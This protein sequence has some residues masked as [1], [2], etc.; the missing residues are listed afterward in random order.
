MRSAE[1]DDNF[2][3]GIEGYPTIEELNNGHAS[4]NRFTMTKK[5]TESSKKRHYSQPGLSHKSRGPASTRPVRSMASMD[6]IV[7]D[8]IQRKFIP[9]KTITDTNEP[10]YETTGPQ[11]MAI[12]AD[13]L[14]SYN[15]NNER[16]YRRKSAEGLNRSNFSNQDVGFPNPTSIHEYKNNA[17]STSSNDLR[18]ANSRQHKISS[19][20]SLASV[21]MLDLHSTSSEE[22][23]RTFKSTL[24]TILSCMYALFLLTLGLILFI[25]DIFIETRLSENYCL[26]LVI[27][28]LIYL[29]YLYIDIRIYTNKAHKYHEEKKQYELSEELQRAGLDQSTVIPD[30]VKQNVNLSKPATPPKPLD[31][32]Y[33]FTQGRHAGSFYLKMGAAAFFL[34]HLVH[35]I[36]F[37]SLQVIYLI[38]DLDDDC[39]SIN[40]LIL[41]I[42]YPLYSCIQLFFIFKYSNVIIIKCKELGR[43]ALMHCIASSLCF[44]VW[45]I[46]R[47]I[48][49]SLTVYAKKKAQKGDYG[50]SSEEVKMLKSAQPWDPKF[51]FNIS[52]LADDV[53][54]SVH[55]F[56][57]IIE[58][59]FPY[60]YPF[61]IEFSILIAGVFFILW[62]NIDS[63]SKEDDVHAQNDL[64][65]KTDWDSYNTSPSHETDQCKIPTPIDGNQA[66]SNLTLS[67]DCHSSN[68][69]W[70]GGLMVLVASI[71]SIIVCFIAISNKNTAP[72]GS[73]LK[74]VSELCLHLIMLVAA[75][76]AYY[77]IRR[78][79]VNPHP[80]S[81]LDDLLLF[82]CIPAFYMEAC[83]TL[84]PTAIHL[85]FVKFFN[86]LLMVLQVTVQTP[87]IIDALRRCSNSRKLRKIKPGR[88]LITFLIVCNVATWIFETFSI[89]NADVEDARYEYYGKILW[90]ILGHISTP[91]CMFYR[92][93]SSVCLA[94]IWK[95]AYEPG[96]SH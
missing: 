6:D 58:S 35:S 94:D 75:V 47:E 20:F 7:Y 4:E 59:V 54:L 33:C 16:L 65:D 77:Q 62:Q 63:C 95:C 89:K 10:I 73:M 23:D 74:D 79:D 15:S 24:T 49:E 3:E 13:T 17:F 46:I 34:G 40:V 21:D 56:D 86:V 92:F 66:E 29:I 93:H 52:T 50:N 11:V 88:E 51:R 61:T 68:R 30:Y 19:A 81:L 53:C 91:L 87:M 76:F 90:T 14:S 41:D 1:E 31:H 8:P 72:F 27:V 28:G 18:S 84:V 39:G 82:V 48:M 78:L 64:P 60:L 38:S 80:I 12:T 9:R 36:L 45:T 37:L 71:V 25:A 26:Y 96:N 42:L 70:F 67:I 43:F 44:W 83:F 2:P 69:G 22:K 57:N 85:S 32:P 55:E 5:P